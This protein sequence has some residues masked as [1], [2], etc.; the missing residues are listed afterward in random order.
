MPLNWSSVGYFGTFW[1]TIFTDLRNKQTPSYFSLIFTISSFFFSSF[2]IGNENGQASI[3]AVRWK[4]SAKSQGREC[5][6]KEAV[7]KKKQNT[8]WKGEYLKVKLRYLCV[9]KLCQKKNAFFF[10]FGHFLLSPRIHKNKKW[11]VKVT[12]R[13]IQTGLTWSEKKAPLLE[14]LSPG[15]HP[16]EDFGKADVSVC[17][18]FLSGEQLGKSLRALHAQWGSQ[19]KKKKTTPCHWYYSR[20]LGDR[21]E[22]AAG[23]SRQSI[24]CLAYKAPVLCV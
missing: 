8:V 7:R 11:N 2:A 18:A 22:Y 6:F 12:K 20:P 15:Y 24:N 14:D 9:P 17:N 3:T 23:S 4:D 10:F 1:Y 21:K 16:T 19:G 13:V 5:R